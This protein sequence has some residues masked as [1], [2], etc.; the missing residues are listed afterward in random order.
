MSSFGT[1]RDVLRQDQP[2][3]CG[4]WQVRY[5]RGLSPEIGNLVII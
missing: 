2:E 3:M 4:G 5:R 1:S